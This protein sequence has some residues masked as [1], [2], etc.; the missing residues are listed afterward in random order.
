M[1]GKDSRKLIL[2]LLAWCFYSA[3]AF[4]VENNVVS[5]KTDESI[6]LGSYFKILE[7]PDGKLTLSDILNQ[8]AKYPF[9]DTKSPVSQLGDRNSTFWLKLQYQLPSLDD[10]W[11]ITIDYPHLR[12]I[13]VF[14]YSDNAYE[15]IVYTGYDHSPQVETPDVHGFGFFLPRKLGEAELYLRVSSDSPLIVPAH[16]HTLNKVLET[17]KLNNR[18]RGLFYGIFFVMAAFNLF[19]FFTTRNESYIYYA[20]YIGAIFVYT[21]SNDGVI[22]RYLLSHIGIHM[23]YGMHMQT[24]IVPIIFGALFC[25]HILYT[26]DRLPYFHRLF[27]AMIV[28]SVAISAIIVLFGS[29]IFPRAVMLLTLSFAFLAITAGIF[30]WKSG[31]PTARFFSI[32][33]IAVL[34]GSFTWIFT[35][36]DIVPYNQFSMFSLHAGAACE[37]ILLSM[38]LGDR[39]RLL[40]QERLALE[41][42]AQE[43]LRRSNQQ[44]EASNKFKDEFLSVISHELR[45]PMNGIFGATELLKFTNPSDEQQNYID[46]V[47]NSSKDM[48]KMVEDIL[49]YTQ[50]EAETLKENSV[51]F[52]LKNM[53]SPLLR[54]YQNR[55]EA[56]GVKFLADIDTNIPNKI[57]GDKIKIRLV[58]QHILDNAWK[59]TDQGQVEFKCQVISD[60]HDEI[61]LEFSVA[62]TGCG[63]PEQMKDSIF[64]SFRQVDGSLTRAK[65]GLGIGLALCKN[66]IEI[67]SGTLQFESQE[68]QGTRV[69][70]CLNLES[71]CGN[72]GTIHDKRQAAFP[73]L[74]VG[75]KVLIV[76]DNPVNKLVLVA[77]I[78]K[79]GLVSEAVVNG[80]EAVDYLTDHQVDVVLMDC[81]M[82]VM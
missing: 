65:G 34:L 69:T 17:E 60:A 40:E 58:L 23:N 49:T 66:I 47:A 36:L 73:Q 80:K 19:I 5:A 41:K 75:K 6:L 53:L 50:C 67:L 29:Q 52:D 64:E 33:W 56:K 27:N 4:A 71:N 76:E 35:L 15:R 2:C 70:L 45:T 18:L 51:E 81:Q 77:L 12:D 42:K 11:V 74:K 38:A 63:V 20:L 7:D 3:T 72:N 39:I 78:K 8:P 28:V 9:K 32:A 48:L 46:T 54:E 62:D 55:C 14:S 79:L 44:L 57:R 68:N 30:A 1:P 21:L 43:Q 61:K 22:G 37:T 13:E 10:R 31:M 25:Q 26:K 82:P 24:V 16:L 59:F